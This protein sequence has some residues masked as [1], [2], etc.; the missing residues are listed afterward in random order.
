MRYQ[1]KQASRF[2]LPALLFGMLFFTACENDLNKIKQ[3]SALQL[4]QP[5]D[6]SRGIEIIYSDSAIVKARVISPLMIEYTTAKPY[7]KMPDG[8]KVIHYDIYAREDGNIVAD[9]GVLRKNE[10]IFE[11]HK[12]VVATDAKGRTFKSDELIW[13]QVKKIIYSN[14]PVQ[15]TNKEGDVLYSINFKSDEDFKDPK[16]EQATGFGNIGAF[17]DI[18][19]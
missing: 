11:F 19:H 16:W 13:D 8:I 7:Y 10:K 14:K 4:I 17:S 15:M 18:A 2:I 12:N 6:T 1:A 5:I 3:V 9:S